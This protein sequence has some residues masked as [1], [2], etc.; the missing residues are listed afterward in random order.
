MFPL[1]N[2]NATPLVRDVWQRSVLSSS[3]NYQLN[4]TNVILKESVKTFDSF[5]WYDSFDM[6]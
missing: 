1:H 3:F 6:P 5:A 2:R 4:I